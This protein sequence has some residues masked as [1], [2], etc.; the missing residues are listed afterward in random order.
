MQKT[1]SIIIPIYSDEK[2][3][4]STIEQLILF[5]KTQH[6]KGEIIVVNDGGKDRGVAIVKEKMK[7]HS[8]VKLIN[9]AIN[10]G[11]GYS[12]REGLAVAQEEYIFYTDADLPYGTNTILQILEMLSQKKADV[13][14]ANRETSNIDYYKYTSIPRHITHIIFSLFVRTFIPMR[15]HD[16]LAGLKGMRQ[17]VVQAILSKLSIDRFSFDVELI[18]AAQKAGF[19]VKDIPVTLENAGV[20]NLA[21]VRDAPQMAKDI[22]KIFIRNALGKYNATQAKK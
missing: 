3:I 14:L 17:E 20:S 7:Q 16:T 5:Y 1:I 11:K 21:I 10:H 8:A 6:L 19:F 13:V 12:V 2:T 22:I 15:F 9:R 4:G 18:L